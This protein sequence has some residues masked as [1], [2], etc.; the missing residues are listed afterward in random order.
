V[1]VAADQELHR[2]L[3]MDLAPRFQ[4]HLV[5]DID[6][7]ALQRIIDGLTQVNRRLDVY[8]L[9]SNGMIKEWF[10]DADRRPLLDAVDPAPLDRFMAG[11]PAPVLAE[12]PA[13]PG[14]YRPFSAAPVS[15]MGEEGCYLYLILQGEAYDDVLAMLRGPLFGR[16]ALRAAL[17]AFAVTA[18]VGLVMFW[19]LSRR[20]TLLRA[21]VADFE[22]GRLDRRF[23][24][25]SDD[26]LGRLCLAFNAMADRIAGQVEAL[27]ETDEL[28]RE[29]VANVSHDLRS[30]LAALHGYLETLLIKDDQLDADHRHRY[31]ESAL[32]QSH[33]LGG[34]VGQLF[35]LSKLDAGQVEPQLEAFPLAELVQ[36][37][38]MHCEP[39]AEQRGIALRAVL[40]EQGLLP[41]LADVGLVERVLSNLLDNALRFTPP[42]GAVEVHLRADDGKVCVDVTDTGE[43]IPP[44]HL[45]HVFDRF[46]RGDAARVNGD[47]AGLGLSIAQRIVELHGGT[48]AAESVPGEGTRFTFSIPTA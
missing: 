44:E 19:W 18:L 9:G 41:V 4:P 40:P 28:R 30:P 43:G 7:T 34:L 35:E 20:L 48:I 22:A 42:G 46:Y 3:A 10:M 36:D 23:P 38:V 2:D 13:R 14:T 47:G 27:R 16:L 24:G 37:V 6:T 1:A 11:A 5:T 26:E 15:I 31:L 32:A 8:L 17:L 29:L 12:D 45:P 39:E 33:R 21:V 25:R